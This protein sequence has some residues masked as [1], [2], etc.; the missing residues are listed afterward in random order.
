MPMNQTAQKL[1]AVREYAVKQGIKAALSLHQE[2]SHLVRL[3]NSGVSLNTSE[4]L[5]RFSVTAYGD[6]KTATAQV[7]CDPDDQAALFEAVDKA[8]SMLA[9]CQHAQLPAH[10]PGDSGNRHPPGGL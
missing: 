3:A 2:D 4:A 10:L 7:M 6:H 8:G 5:S 1:L 9:S